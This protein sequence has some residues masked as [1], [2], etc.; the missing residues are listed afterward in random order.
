MGTRLCYILILSLLWS[1]VQGQGKDDIPTSGINPVI[2]GYFADPT[3][4]K[5]GDLYYIYAT[6]DNEMLASGV[7]TVWYSDD[8]VNWYNHTMEVPSLDEVQLRNFW[9]PDIVEGA[10]GFYYLYF[11][12]CQAGCNIYGYRSASPVGPWE[13][14]SADDTPVIANNYPREGF[15]SLDAQFFRDDDRRIYAY[16][17]TW[18]HYNG[19][20]AVGE[21]DTLTMARVTNPNNIPLEQTPGPFEAAYM[22]K[23]GDKYILMYSGGSCHDE[24]YKVNYSHGD[25]PYGPFVPGENN[26]ILATNG[27]GSVHGP[28]HHSVLEE[29]GR[30]YI[31]YHKHD[32][33]MTRG[34]MSRQVCV[35]QLIFENDSTIQRVRPSN[36]GIEELSGPG[37]PNN[38]ALGATATAS[39]SYHLDIPGYDYTYRPE[40]ATDNHN[41]TMWKAADNSFPQHLTLDLGGVRK[42]SRVMLQFEFA[43]Y[44]YQ[45]KLEHSTDGT[46]WVPYADRSENRFPGSPMIDEGEA[47][48]R[49]LRLTVL[50]T[51]KTGLY[52]ALWNFKVYD[53]LFEIPLD[54]K[55]KASMEGPSAKGDRKLLME[56]RAKDFPR[57]KFESLPNN[58]HSGG[59]F[60]RKGDVALVRDELGIPAL[61]FTKGALVLDR[62][63]PKSMEWNGAFT[64]A[65]WV[66]NPEIDQ[67]GECLLSWCDRFRFNLANSY[68]ALHFNSGNYGAAAHLDHHFDMG[69]NTL[70]SA[71]TWHHI[72]LTFDGVVEKLY[73]DGELDNAQ[74]MVLASQIENAKIRIGASDIGEHYT[75]LMASMS[76]FD[77][78]LDQG[79]ITE[80]ME[81]TRPNA[82]NR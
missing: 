63:V 64:V 69:F 68:N 15:P 76:L 30:Y 4:K 25:T 8:F 35:D 5:F 81:S 49:Y 65:T 12:N 78:A 23:K 36:K 27:D 29:N 9:A 38:L 50:D 62:P 14:L 57:G 70:P 40:F 16:W 13:K 28:G 32:H 26:P 58:G 20:Y 43:G 67:K 21:L 19:G 77:H 44:Y 22:L 18:V 66:K 17:G 51:E 39:S 55:P 61:E 71:N 7:P 10:D 6:T 59:T 79:E 31:A 75:G 46:H 1:N 56:I 2:P 47:E 34:G 53:S 54:L 3:I 82:K 11:G 45:Y 74:I 48:A 41:A 33:P 24:T 72:V 42:I 52:A 80:L 37:L 73:V 60:E